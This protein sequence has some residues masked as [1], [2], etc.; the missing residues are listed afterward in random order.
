[1]KITLFSNNVKYFCN[2]FYNYASLLDIPS[3]DLKWDFKDKPSNFKTLKPGQIT[4]S[5]L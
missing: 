4:V 5:I 1:M 2:Y 3:S